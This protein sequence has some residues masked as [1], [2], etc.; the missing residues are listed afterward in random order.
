MDED[1]VVP[2]NSIKRSYAIVD[3]LRE[4]GRAGA[5]ELADALSLPKSTVHNHLRTLATLGYLV[6]EEG[7]YRLGAQYLHVGQESRNT[8]TVFQHGRDTVESLA[9]KSGRY[10]QLVIEENGDAAV[11][12]STQWVPDEGTR[13]TQQAYPMRAP[14]YTNAPGKAILAHLP[15]ERITQI[16]ERQDLTART[17]LTV[18]DEDDLRSEMATIRDQGYAIDR[19]ELI[20]GMVGVA[21]P[22]VT[23]KCV[24]GAVAAYGAGNEMREALDESLPD[25]ITESAD[26]IRADIVFAGPE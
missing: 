2:I 5:T 9:E 16:V 1:L 12:Q 11:I 20:S 17:E 13:A 18:T 3:E 4:R 24:Y 6:E 8:R 25:L 10:C 15:P 7:S 23:E 14:L 26:D 19:G 22:I 21:A